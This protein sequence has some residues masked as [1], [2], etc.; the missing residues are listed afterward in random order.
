M[1]TWKKFLLKFLL[2]S[3]LL[4]MLYL[5]LGQTATVLL[6]IYQMIKDCNPS[7]TQAAIKISTLDIDKDDTD[8]CFWLTS[9]AR[10]LIQIY[11]LFVQLKGNAIEQKQLLE[12]GFI[13]AKSKIIAK[14][15]EY[16]YQGWDDIRSALNGILIYYINLRF[17]REFDPNHPSYPG[18]PPQ[19]ELIKLS[20]EQLEEEG[21]NEGIDSLLF[22]NVQHG[23]VPLWLSTE[24]TKG[25]ILNNYWNREDQ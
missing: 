7:F 17:G 10:Y 8:L 1:F 13:R 20:D 15:I 2:G 16:I 21:T 19:P 25:E 24:L 9:F 18:F 14:Y 22:N 11:L 6:V 5:V 4:A 12:V 3:S 23:N